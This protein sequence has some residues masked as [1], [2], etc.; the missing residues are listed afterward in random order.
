M[1]IIF[2]S[3]YN[4]QKWIESDV[5]NMCFYELAAIAKYF[6]FIT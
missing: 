1:R 6:T 3:N 5:E 4:E 2:I